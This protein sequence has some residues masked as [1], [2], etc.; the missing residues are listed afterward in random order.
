[1][2]SY[3]VDTSIHFHIKFC[4][5]WDSCIFCWLFI[6]INFNMMYTWYGFERLFLDKGLSDDTM[7]TPDEKAPSPMTTDWMNQ[8]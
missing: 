4:A 7:Q 3:V 1:M 5:L 6:I 2:Y 8:N